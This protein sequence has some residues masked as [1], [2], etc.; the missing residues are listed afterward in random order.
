MSQ[1]IVGYWHSK[2]TPEYPMPEARENTWEGQEDF[3]AR[4]H[5]KESKM[6]QVRYRGFSTCRICSC[7][8]GSTEFQNSKFRWPSGLRHYIETHNVKPD[9]EFIDWVTG[10]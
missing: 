9:Q 10:S 1:K 3:L 7:I 8:N 4:L 2:L 5:N 6:H